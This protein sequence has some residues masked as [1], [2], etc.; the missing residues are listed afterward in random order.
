MNIS[1]NIS[2]LFSIYGPLKSVMCSVLYV[3]WKII[4]I[5]IWGGEG[6]VIDKTNYRKVV[7]VNS[8]LKL[9]KYRDDVIT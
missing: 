3:Y 9:T 7:V 6:V 2:S 1:L 4:A 8:G 5:Y